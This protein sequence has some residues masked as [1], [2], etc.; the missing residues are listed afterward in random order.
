MADQTPAE[1]NH[2]K[3]Q[4]ADL[5]ELGAGLRRARGEPDP[6]T[7]GP[8][9]V[10]SREM[11]L[12]F[13]VAIE[14]AAAM[15]VGSLIGWFLDKW[16]GTTPWLLMLFLILGMASGTLTAFRAATSA[17]GKDDQ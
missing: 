12:A 17:G 1:P 2:P 10:N 16:L 3:N 11:N 4:P 15:F 6:E 7:P 14:L 13:R 5:Q 8:G 9:R